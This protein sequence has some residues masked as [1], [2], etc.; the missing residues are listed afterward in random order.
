MPHLSQVPGAR[1]FDGRGC[2]FPL[3]GGTIA[4]GTP[5][6][7]ATLWLAT[8]Q[9][10]RLAR[11]V[12][13]GA[14]R[15]PSPNRRTLC[16]PGRDFVPNCHLCPNPPTIPPDLVWQ[17]RITSSPN[18]HSLRRTR[19]PKGR[20]KPQVRMMRRSYP[21]ERVSPFTNAG[22]ARM[23]ERAG[24]VLKLSFNP[25]PHMVRHA[26]GFALANRRPRHKSCRPISGTAMS[27]YRRY[28][29]CRRPVSRIFGANDCARTVS[30]LL[31]N[32]AK[33]RQP[34]LLATSSQTSARGTPAQPALRRMPKALRAKSSHPGRYLA[35]HLF[36]TYS[37]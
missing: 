33:L 17:D 5:Q 14:D 25:H 8:W 31:P 36:S 19:Q 2:R 34:M 18:A 1:R 37:P 23:L 15:R 3:P 21:L 10:H 7:A 29:S 4:H 11:K 6:R 27:A 28:T 12:N 32:S 24:T 30:E 26:C 20:K 22:F 16:A 35:R 13:R 9:G